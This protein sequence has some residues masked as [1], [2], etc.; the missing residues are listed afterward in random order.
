[1]SKNKFRKKH[2]KV[3]FLKFLLERSELPKCTFCKNNY[4]NYKFDDFDMHHLFLSTLGKRCS[5]CIN[6][7]AYRKMKEEKRNNLYWYEDNFKPLYDWEEE[8]DQGE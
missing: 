5:S 4:K 1:M 7:T 8:N 2:T 3:E 6:S